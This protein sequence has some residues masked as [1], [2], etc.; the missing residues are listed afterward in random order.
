ME[1]LN[2][3]YRKFS[4]LINVGDLRSSLF[5]VFLEPNFRHLTRKF[6]INF[7]ICFITFLFCIKFFETFFEF[8][9]AVDKGE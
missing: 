1:Y 4:K 6:L 3:A 8:L 2:V 5:D 9:D 7:K